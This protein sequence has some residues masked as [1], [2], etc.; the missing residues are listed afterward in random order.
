MSKK[1]AAEELVPVDYDRC[2]ADVP[3]GYS[4]MTLG[5]QPG[6]ERCREELA[7]IVSEDKPSKKDGLRGAMSLCKKCLAVFKKQCPDEKVTVWRKE[8]RK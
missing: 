5:G 7:V 8:P 6:R 2:Q 1:I 3:N 4:F